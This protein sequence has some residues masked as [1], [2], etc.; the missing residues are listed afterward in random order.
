M[1]KLM[2][3]YRHPPDFDAFMS[4]YLN[5]HLPLVR[6]LPGLVHLDVTRIKRSL[7]GESPY[8]LIATMGFADKESY[9]AAMRSPENAALGEDLKQFAADL[10]TVVQAETI[11]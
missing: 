4:H 9:Q 2:A 1:I 8:V 10:A 7:I 3:F 11:D 6:R 5:V